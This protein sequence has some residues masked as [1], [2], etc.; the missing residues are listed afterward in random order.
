LI[1]FDIEQ[2]YQDEAVVGTAISRREGV[3][4]SVVMHA[5]M[6]ALILLLPQLPYFERGAEEQQRLEEARLQAEE[7]E[8]ENPTFVFVRPRADVEAPTPPE[9][10]E[11]SDI[12]RQSS[13][14]VVAPD[15]INPLPLSQ[16]DS[17]DRVE[18][19]QEESELAAADPQP[20]PPAPPDPTTPV[21]EVPSPLAQ[22][23]T[24]VG[25]PSGALR[26]PETGALGEALRNLQRYVQKGSFDNPRGGASQPGAAIQFDTRGVEF[27]PWI[28]RFVAQVKRNW[29]V[30]NAA[31][32]MKGHVV[33]QF[34]IHKDGRVSDIAVV[35]PSAIEAF[36]N[37]AYNAILT[38]NPTE[39]L[40]PEYPEEQT[41]FT[42][43][44][45]YNEE[46]P[47]Y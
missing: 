16:G 4:L 27:G 20:T 36:N 9:R 28:R 23:E 7:R 29:F 22:T 10:S 42:V 44:F 14:P 46:A 24:G 18:E 26:M 2:R 47:P 3:V 17:S 39:P 5:T 30:P 6:A 40:P 8:Q 13:A 33:L 41:L 32:L 35:G 25:Q 15:P 19:S 1:H 11:L 38:S 21:S 31:W 45:F 43:T 34:N 37:A 12:D